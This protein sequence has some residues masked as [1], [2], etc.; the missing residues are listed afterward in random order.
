MGIAGFGGPNA[1]LPPYS[2]LNSGQFPSPWWDYASTEF[3]ESMPMALRYCEYIFIKNGIY[4]SAV[5]RL[6]SYFITDLDITG[7]DLGKDEEDKWKTFF[8]DDLGYASILH[9]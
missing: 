6:L 9:T 1:F 8:Y 4:R 3:P 2:G 5:D 7:K